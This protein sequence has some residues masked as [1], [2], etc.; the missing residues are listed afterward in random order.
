[1]KCC[2]EETEDNFGEKLKHAAERSGNDKETGKAKIKQRTLGTERQ[3]GK[4]I[5]VF[6]DGTG[7]EGGEGNNTNVYKLFNTVLDRSPEQFAFYDRGLGTGWRKFTGNVSGMGISK[8]I[9]DCYRFIFDNFES[10]DEIFLLGFS[11]GAT[12]VRSLS[13]FIHY[14]G[15]L[16][17]ARPELIKR[18]Y[19]IYRISDDKKRKAEADAFVAR[20]HTMWCKIKFLGVWD[21]VAALGVPF[22][23]FDV[24]ID[25]IPFFK[26][27]F[28]DLRLS[29]SVVHACH[30][31]AIDDER[32]TFHP[33]LW[34]PKI[35]EDQ[36][37]KQVWFCGMH[38]DVGGGYK[39]PE[40]SDIALD[41]MR[42]EAMEH[43]LRI[44]RETK[45][46]GNADGTM[47]D[48]REG[49]RSFFRRKVR[50]W[51]RDT[52]GNPRIHASVLERKLNRHNKKD[53]EYKPWIL[54][55]SYSYDI[56]P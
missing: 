1:M 35:G 39:E 18:A 45:S 46:L 3:M 56:E 30:A 52:H 10:G 51:P 26:Q 36:T 8:N 16:P 9:Q 7:Q 17:K 24:I 11:R 25:Q 28:H 29:E 14:F 5:V 23:G 47:H 20:H 2:R 37:M 12:T 6:S 22:R 13:S 40:L 53:P 27:S 38:T 50:S 42:R 54:D 43:G 4:N 33:T 21:T 15:I 41:W 55:G 44:Y 19:K 49:G 48:S 34:D 32:R 31:L